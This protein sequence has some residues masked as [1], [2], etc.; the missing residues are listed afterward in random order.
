MLRVPE[1]I[2]DYVQQQLGR[3]VR[4]RRQTLVNAN[5]AD[6][7]T[8]WPAGP[9]EP[10]GSDQVRRLQ[11]Y[12]FRSSPPAGAEL[13]TVAVGGAAG[14][15]VAFASEAPGAGPTD[16][17]SGDVA[18]YCADGAT[19]RV[20]ANG[21]TILIDAN[22][23]ITADCAPGQDVVVNGGTLKVARETDPVDLGY[24]VVTPGA[25]GVGAVEWLPPGSPMPAPPAVAT[26]MQGAISGGAPHFKG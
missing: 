16:Q 9:G 6:E 25:G 19:V 14:Q 23:A 22:G 21:A 18:V 3:L 5:G 20:I 7:V 10:D 4:Y 8:G 2:R 17:A 15:H 24:L 12:G 11:H 26:P 1:A 13:L